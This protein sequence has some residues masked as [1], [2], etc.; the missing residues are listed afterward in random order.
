MAFKR[1]YAVLSR[2][3]ISF[4]TLFR[5]LCFFI[6]GVPKRFVDLLFYFIF[7]NKGG[8]KDGLENL[9][10][11][12]YYELRY[13]KI[14]VLE[15][16]FTLNC[17]SI[18]KIVLKLSNKYNSER[19]F[20]VICV[21]KEVSRDFS[22]YE[23]KNQKYVRMIS[24]GIV[25]EEGVNIRTPHYLYEEKGNIMH[26]TSNINVSLEKSQFKEVAI[27]TLIKDGAKNPG[28]IVSKNAKISFITQGS[29]MVPMYELD[30]IKY[31][32]IEFFD[33]SQDAYKYI[34]H[35]NLVYRD[36]MRSH[37]GYVDEDLVKELTSN[38]YT[39]VLSNATNEDIFNEINKYNRDEVL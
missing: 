23:L 3:K 14:E 13:L 8:F 16:K 36:V 29:K 5:S 22:D 28:T 27:N 33:L 6:L 7:T 11:H 20:N 38:H 4:Y 26:G 10:Y 32:R 37:L 39:A 34:Y 35:K 21:F 31:S 19:V 9:Y 18:G 17:S 24:A 1:I 25:T 2:R 30:A 15:S 12:S